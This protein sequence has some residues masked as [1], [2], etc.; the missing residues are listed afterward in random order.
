ML[1]VSEYAVS[2]G[3]KVK[4]LKDHRLGTTGIVVASSYGFLLC[5]NHEETLLYSFKKKNCCSFLVLN[6]YRV[7]I[8]FKY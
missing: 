8:M 4:S 2:F 1:F 3:T 7:L 6:V 5:I